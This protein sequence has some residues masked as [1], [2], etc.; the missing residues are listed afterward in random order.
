M[1]ER[2]HSPSAIRTA[3]YQSQALPG[4]SLALDERS[5]IAIAVH[6]SRKAHANRKLSSRG[7]QSPQFPMSLESRAEITT[8]F[9]MVWTCFGLAVHTGEWRLYISPVPAANS[10]TAHPYRS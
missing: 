7:N 2:P 4:R 5:L 8:Y 3:V 10:A 1:E 9:V 6:V